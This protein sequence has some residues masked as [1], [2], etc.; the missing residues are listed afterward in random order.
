MKAEAVSQS[1][2]TGLYEGSCADREHNER[3]LTFP[4]NA[5]VALLIDVR[6]TRAIY[7]MSVFWQRKGLE[8]TA[9][10]VESC[11]REAAARSS[12]TEAPTDGAAP[13]PS[14]EAFDQNV[15]WRLA[16]AVIRS[17][18]GFRVAGAGTEAA[19]VPGELG[20]TPAVRVDPSGSV[21]VDD[22]PRRV[23]LAGLRL[24]GAA[25]TAPGPARALLE[26]GVFHV[27]WRLPSD[28]AATP[29][30]I[31]LA[32]GALCQGIRH[33]EI[34]Q[35]FAAKLESEQDGLTALLG[36]YEACAAVLSGQVRG[37]TGRWG[38]GEEV[39]GCFYLCLERRV[40][41]RDLLSTDNIVHCFVLTCRVF[42][43]VQRNRAGFQLE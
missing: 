43:L 37:G 40:F 21:H 27:L 42:F 8:A 6:P 35:V 3:G 2:N 1:C 14:G 7:K 28:P 33:A 12:S 32:L 29:T 15:S 23:A 26:S 24:A 34:L 31:A 13:I 19:A 41:D 4:C 39:V 16:T 9:D 10:S 17:M 38:H 20:H 36:G 11:F 18:R 22:G 30:G 5:V 25:A